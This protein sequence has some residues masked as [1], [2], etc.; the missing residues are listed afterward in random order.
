MSE[1]SIIQFIRQPQ[2]TQP[3]SRSTSRI[4]MHYFPDTLHYRDQDLQTWLPE[5]KAL[6]I[7]WLTLI[8]P[9][10]R[11]IPEDFLRG[12]IGA[13]IEPILHFP[14][15]LNL[16][17]LE[18]QIRRDFTRDFTVLFNNYARWGTHYVTLF[19]RPNVRRSWPASAWTQENLVERF[20]DIFIPLAETALQAE[21]TPVFPPLEPGGDYWDTAF[22][23]SALRSLQRRCIQTS[24]KSHL[25]EQIT[26]GCYAWT[27]DRPLEWGAGGPEQWPSA[28]PYYTPEGSQDQLGFRIFDWYAAIAQAEMGRSVPILLLR[29]GSRLGENPYGQSSTDELRQHAEVNL[30][31]YQL[32]SSQTAENANQQSEN[33]KGVTAGLSEENSFLNQGQHAVLCANYWLLAAA[34]ES[35]YVTSAWYQADGKMLPIVSAL[36]QSV[37][38]QVDIQPTSNKGYLPPRAEFIPSTSTHPIDHY[39]LLPIYAWGV[40]DWDLE[41]IRPFLQQHHATVGFS[42][43]EARLANRVTILGDAARISQDALTILRLAGCQIEQ[44]N[45]DGT[46]LAFS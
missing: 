33:R 8:A 40:A 18:S 1:A 43:Y 12:L 11:A 36:K 7:H 26:L 4:G 21:L 5:L 32:F 13:G 24:G 3:P 35:P 44:L 16:N 46:L 41:A 9:V 34:P 23:Q 25:A 45:Q 15:P 20:L 2:M 29:C 39:L 42:V 31:I 6:G 10:E 22:L 19:D 37:Q 27:F 17:I 30:S 14:L 28:Q 38:S